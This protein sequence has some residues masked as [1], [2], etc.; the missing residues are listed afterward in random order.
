MT[1]TTMTNRRDSTFEV[2]VTI[3]GI[4]LRNG[5]ARSYNM[6]AEQWNALAS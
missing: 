1:A 3:N 5:G 6:A 2:L 4:L